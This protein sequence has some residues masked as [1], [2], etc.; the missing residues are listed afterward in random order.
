MMAALHGKERFAA[1]PFFFPTSFGKLSGLN[2][3]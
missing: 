1:G 3:A 2:F